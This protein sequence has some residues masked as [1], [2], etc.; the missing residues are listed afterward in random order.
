MP[1]KLSDRKKRELKKAF[2][3]QACKYLIFFW[4][5][6]ERVKQAER[7][8]GEGWGTGGKCLITRSNRRSYSHICGRF[9]HLGGEKMQA[10][11]L[12]RWRRGRRDDD[13][14]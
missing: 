14:S 4:D 3:C 12:R 9:R 8:V 2:R 11:H 6:P 1:K 5:D 13:L 10:E 7:V